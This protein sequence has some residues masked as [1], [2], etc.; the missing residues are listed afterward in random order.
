MRLT[1]FNYIRLQTFLLIVIVVFSLFN[2]DYFYN[3]T[4]IAYY[5]FCIAVFLFTIVSFFPLH[6][7]EK[8]S[9]KKPVLL[10]G[11]WCLYVVVNYLMD[12]ATLVFTI[13]SAALYFLLLKSTILFSTR[14]FKIMHFLIAIAAIAVLE[15]IHCLMQYLGVLPSLS[16]YYKVTGSWNNPNV[17]AIFLALT[18]PI[19]LYL[20]K[21]RYKKIMLTGLILLLLALLLLKCRAAFIGV[22]F[23]A[24]VYYGLE[25]QFTD[26]IGNK[27][28]S[29]SAKALLVLSLIIMIPACSYLYN[30]KKD[31]ADGRKFIWKLS[32][33]MIKQKPITGYGYGYFEKEYNLYQVD[34]IK[35]GKATP[36]ESA[37]AGPV[38]MPHNEL[39]LSA[40]E[41]GGLGLVLILWFFASLIFTV[42]QKKRYLNPQETAHVP[43]AKNSFFN[44]AYAAIISFILMSMV[45][46]TIQIIPIMCLMIIYSG[47]ICST[48]QPVGFLKNNRIISIAANSVMIVISMYLIFLLFGM[49]LADRQNKKAKLL[50][51]AGNYQEALKIMGSI[52][53]SLKENSDY[54]QNY[55]HLNFKIKNYQQAAVCFKKAKT[56]SSLPPLYLG[57]GKVHEKMKQYPQ[58]IR[59][60][61]TLAALYPSKFLYRMLLL[62]AYVMDKDTASAVITAAKIIELKPKI[63]SEK[64]NAYKNK[65]RFL[66]RKLDDQKTH[67]KHFQSQ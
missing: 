51:G 27:K 32:A 67:R 23:S 15:S 18:V 11:L 64:V 33:G 61:E 29:T 10:F 20:L 40:V 13:Y 57:A 65:C 46:S 30:I 56:F 12:K 1:A 17:T 37:H 49:A 6:S 45:N 24:I 9:C 59:E 3:S 47:L 54:W 62:D 52:E 31:S 58:A 25:Y 21:D 2:N 36:E 22:I 50:K 28:N 14:T 16:I 48:V 4:A 41:G 5:G 38:I 35:N 53:S 8:F 7:N 39:L 44:L 60:Y 26:W 43:A 66:L 42:R 55:G 63:V 19:F 34:Y